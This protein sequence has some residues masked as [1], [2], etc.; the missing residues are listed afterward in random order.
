VG[1]AELLC[2]REGDA[3]VALDL[4]KLKISTQSLVAFLITLGGLLQI[5][6]VSAFVLG[7]AAKH[8]H[9]AVAVG[10]ITGIAA[11]LHNPQVEQA[12]GIKQTVQV[13]TEQVS[14]AP[15]GD[16]K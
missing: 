16:S 9:I 12:L 4:S 8:P 14:V 15:P 3:V 13:T 11:L 5:P 7:L 2:G 10:V 6:Q 1:G